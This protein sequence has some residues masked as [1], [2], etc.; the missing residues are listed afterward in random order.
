MVM[1]STRGRGFTLLEIM[2]V[3]LIIGILLAIA[4]PQFINSRTRSQQRACIS[5][6]RGIESAKELYTYKN[7][8]KQGDP[9][10][11]NLAWTDYSRQPYPICPSGGSYTVGLVGELPSC[12]LNAATPPHMIG[13]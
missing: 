11:G 7:N 3:I 5:S 9:I 10:D 12:S 6:L 2:V 8:L 1:K 4:V 13:N